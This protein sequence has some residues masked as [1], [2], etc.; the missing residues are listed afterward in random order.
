[1]SGDDEQGVV[2]PDGEA[3]HQGQQRRRRRDA[4]ERRREKDQRDRQPDADDRRQQGE[5]GDHEGAE[6]HDQHEQRDQQADGFGDRHA[7]HRQGEQI[8]AERDFGPC[9]QL[10]L[11]F[12]RDILQRGL[13]AGRNVGRLTVELHAHDRG[14]AVIGDLA[15]DDLA[16]RIRD[17]EDAVQVLEFCDRVGDRRRVR[18]VLDGRAVG[19]DDDHLRTRATGL[20]ERASQLLDAG[21]GLGSRDREGVVRPLPERRRAD[22]GDAQKQQPGDQHPPRMT[23]RPPAERV[24]E[25]G[26][27]ASGLPGFRQDGYSAVSDT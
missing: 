6:C 27:S 19:R 18:L 16:E 4:R 25:S 22:P 3:Q 12:G 11:Q 5:P 20:G 24:Q 17:G 23:V 13:R 2:D 14:I 1:M 15:V 8:T 26:H 10:L 9:G 21:L 7:R